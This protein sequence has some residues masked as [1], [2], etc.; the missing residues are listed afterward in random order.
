MTRKDKIKAHFED[1]KQFYIGLGIGLGL[2]GITWL[3]VKERYPTLTDSVGVARE[4]RTVLVAGAEPT[5]SLTFAK[6]LFGDATN[7][8]TTNYNGGRG[9]PGFITRCV[10]TGELFLTQGDAARAFGIPES[11]LSKH[12]NYGRELLENLHFERVGVL[13]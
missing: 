11:I 9:N 13:S 2:A 7:V 12:L 8:V 6:S 4:P 1:H 10:E 5:G 3:I